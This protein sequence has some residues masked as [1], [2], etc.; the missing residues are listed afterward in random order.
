MLKVVEEINGYGI[1]AIQLSVL[2]TEDD[3][4]D[5]LEDALIFGLRSQKIQSFLLDSL[6][7]LCQHEIY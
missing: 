2:A 5:G 4:L 1:P 6:L 3:D 7:G